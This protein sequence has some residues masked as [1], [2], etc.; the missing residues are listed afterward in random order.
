[1][2]RSD[3]G[4]HQVKIWLFRHLR[5]GIGLMMVLMGL[6]ASPALAKTL[7][8]EDLRK[9]QEGWYPTGLP[10]VNYTTETGLGYGA[11]V[12]LYNN[13]Q[14]SDPD[15][16][17]TPYFV[18]SY[19]QFFQTTNGQAYHDINLDMPQ[20][21]GTNWRL[22]SES[23]YKYA[24]SANY[25][26]FGAADADAG[27][28]DQTGK[29]Y[30]THEEYQAFLDSGPPDALLQKY[31]K[32]HYEKLATR[33]V[34]SRRIIDWLE[35]VVGFEVGLV[36]IDDWAGKRIDEGDVQGISAPTRLTRD[37][38]QL[39]GTD[40]GWTNQLVLG[41]KI[42]WLDFE[43]NPKQ[44]F[45]GEYI[46]ELSSAL[47]GSDFDYVRQTFSVRGFYTLWK[48]LT[49]GARTAMTYVTQ[50]AP[51]FEMAEMTF[52]NSRFASV[53]GIR[54][55]RGLLS[56]RHIAPGMT[57]AQAEL[58]YFIGDTVI[59]G[60]RF[61]LQPTAFVDSGNVYDTF[62]DI[63]AEPRFAQYKVSYGGGL[64]IPWNL[65]TLIHIYL[66][67]SEEG[68]TISINFNNTF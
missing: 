19:L 7:S 32:Y 13:G 14:R 45:L 54:T 5:A 29:R 46:A 21:L 62:G 47:I 1:M 26:G 15:F 56:S 66:G 57:L 63:F 20:F 36:D 11:R 49:L 24:F 52:F 48:R 34:A 16:D 6:S 51:F 40:G 33:W 43:P 10:L 59:F 58:R 50:E 61:G 25:F 64:V 18:R 41:F 37:A 22:T 38:D 12:Y 68:E 9:K 3:V 4:A 42:D 35:F 30:A 60:Q 28:V 67:F 23:N 8:P 2:G 53:G 44:G 55:N 31:D 27:L 39:I 17:S 65:S